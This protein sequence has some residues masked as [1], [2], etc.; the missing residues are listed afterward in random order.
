METTDLLD[1]VEFEKQQIKS[2]RGGVEMYDVKGHYKYLTLS[3]LVDY[4]FK[5]YG[6]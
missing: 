2:N 5:R 6:T 3:E 4:Y 1:F